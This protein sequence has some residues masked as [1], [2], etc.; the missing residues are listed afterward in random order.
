[1]FFVI[2]PINH[3][4]WQHAMYILSFYSKLVISTFSNGTDADTAY[5]VVES[6]P[7]LE[8]EESELRLAEMNFQGE[9]HQH[10]ERLCPHC[11]DHSDHYDTCGHLA[12]KAPINSMAFDKIFG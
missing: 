11:I 1:M 3:A 7:I 2:Y 9:W 4:D 12:F 8:G 6:K 5:M 10:G